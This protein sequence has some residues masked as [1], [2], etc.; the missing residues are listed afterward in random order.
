MYDIY[1]VVSF[2]GYHGS[3]GA[4]L[5]LD[6]RVFG[7][8]HARAC[9]APLSENEARLDSD[10]HTFKGGAQQAGEAVYCSAG[11]AL[12][13]SPFPLSGPPPS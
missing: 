13:T 11:M 2:P 5:A 1:W 12:S 3:L 10:G 4:R 7:D 6:V 8:A 9:G